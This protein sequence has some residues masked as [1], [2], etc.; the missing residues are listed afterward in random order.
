MDKTFA[1][2]MSKAQKLDTLDQ[3]IKNTFH[4]RD[5]EGMSEEDR[6]KLQDAIDIMCDVYRNIRK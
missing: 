4:L 6:Q 2:K 1:N 3:N 5:A